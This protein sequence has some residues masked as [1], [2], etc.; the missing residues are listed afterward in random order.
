MDVSRWSIELKLAPADRR[1][2]KDLVRNGN[3]AQKLVP[4]AGIALL[5]E[6]LRVSWRPRFLR[7]WGYHDESG[8]T[9]I[10]S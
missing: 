3:T 7:D 10:R 5:S 8:I 9:Q 2:L 4:R 1:R 6:P